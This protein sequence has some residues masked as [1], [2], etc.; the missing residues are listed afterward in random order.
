MTY[1]S[2]QSSRSEG[3]SFRAATVIST[4][5]VLQG[6]R[7]DLWSEWYRVNSIVLL[8]MQNELLCDESEFTIGNKGIF[9]ACSKTLQFIV[10]PT[11][12][13]CYLIYIYIWTARTPTIHF[14]FPVRSVQCIALKFITP[15]Q[16]PFI[17]GSLCTAHTHHCTQQHYSEQHF[18]SSAIKNK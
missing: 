15:N 7:E 1:S 17:G 16:P 11:W 8:V 14:V 9:R 6:T 13:S 3:S 12:S 2:C 5:A 18:H 4:R 10:T